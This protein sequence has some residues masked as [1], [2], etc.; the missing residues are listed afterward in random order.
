MNIVV[1]GFGYTARRFAALRPDHRYSC[2]WREQP[3][4]S[5]PEGPNI[6]AFPFAPSA[7]DGALRERIAEADMALVSIPPDADGD[8]TLRRFADDLRAPNALRHVVYLSTIGVY[9]DA[10]GAWIDETAHRAARS[11]RGLQ[12][13][14]AE[15]NWS[16]AGAEAP[17]RLSILRLAGIYGPGRNVIVKLRQGDARRIV[18]PGQVF[19]RIHVDD[20]GQV[21]DRLVTLEAGREEEA[22]NLADDEPAPPQD[23]IA[24]AAG[25]IGAAIPPEEPFESAAL[26]AMARSFYGD[27][28]RVSNA[29]AKALLGFK[30]LYPTFREGL[31]ALRGE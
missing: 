29:K 3:G 18:K 20:I 28:K 16:Q 8:P 4:A 13:V 6:T 1:F 24:F 10:G 31:M 2:T 5:K 23:V 21:I 19:N 11:E 14:R 30:P 26:S 17:W 27:N 12:R 15:D 9:G 7:D 22:W 25:L